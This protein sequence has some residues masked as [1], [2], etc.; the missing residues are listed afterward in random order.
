VAKTGGAMKKMASAMAIIVFNVFA[1]TVML[2]VALRLFPA[3]IPLD[4]L[5]VFDPGL[6]SEIASRRGLPTLSETELLPRDDGGPPLHLHKPLAIINRPTRD[7]DAVATVQ[8]DELGFCNPPNAAARAAHIDIISIGDSFTYCTGVPPEVTWTHQLSELTG[9]STYNLG[10]PYSGLH[11]YLQILKRYGLRKT[12][13]IVIMTVYQGN[14]LRDA[15]RYH[16]YREAKGDQGRHPGQ[17]TPGF[18]AERSYVYN[19][20]RSLTADAQ[21]KWEE[22]RI[23]STE[24]T[25]IGRQAKVDFHYRMIFAGRTID[26]NPE[27]V[28]QREVRLAQALREKRIPAGVFK[29]L[30]QALKDFVVLAQAHHFVP[31]VVYT[32]S[33]YT[34]YQDHVVFN[35]TG[36]RD[37]MPWFSRQQREFFKSRQA[38]GYRYLDLTL[39]L[40][41]EATRVAPGVLLY[42]RHDLH[43]SRSGHAAVARS[44]QDFLNDA[45]L[46]GR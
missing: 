28:N 15:A 24:H 10:K 26:F 8:M 25:L 39:P 33:A 7:E 46:T 32:P 31:V 36:L 9:L 35:D 42:H 38:L 17:V 41:I 21:L 27:N 6:R 30:E 40:Q 29:D 11:E 13:R 22:R 2:E 14:D 34:V 4:R 44:L 12:P 18:L 20:S 43:L 3:L 5:V 37:L 1:I 23:R 16:M 45:R 19:L